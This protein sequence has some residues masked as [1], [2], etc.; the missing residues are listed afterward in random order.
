MLEVVASLLQVQPDEFERY[1][2]KAHTQIYI[3]T[4][5]TYTHFQKVK[6][7]SPPPCTPMLTCVSLCV[8]CVSA[9]TWRN[10]QAARE[11]VVKERT[12]SE[13]TQTHF[14]PLLLSKTNHVHC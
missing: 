10:I 8:V 6:C 5:T 7:D 9:L 3:H 2:A 11:T 14:L 12:P 1:T 4:Q 13:V